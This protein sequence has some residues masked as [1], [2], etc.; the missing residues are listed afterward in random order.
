MNAA[1]RSSCVLDGIVG[2]LLKFRRNDDLA[3]LGLAVGD[4]DG[5]GPRCSPS[6][7]P[8]RSGEHLVPDGALAGHQAP[9]AAVKRMILSCRSCCSSQEQQPD[10]SEA[11]RRHG[12]CSRTLVNLCRM[13]SNA[14]ARSIWRAART[15]RCADTFPH[16]VPAAQRQRSRY[17]R[18]TAEHDGDLRRVRALEAGAL[19]NRCNSSEGGTE[20]CHDDCIVID[21]WRE[22][23]NL[24]GVK[25]DSV[26]SIFSA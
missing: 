10:S 8:D 4:G 11:W 1:R 12:E 16:L 24:R 17:L 14:A 13:R 22:Q 5:Y 19:E 6:R 9:P 20:L 3:V 15:G 21:A 23:Q 25:E 18:C 7:S 26:D 2:E